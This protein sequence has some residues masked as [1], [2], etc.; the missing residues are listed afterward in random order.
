MLAVICII[1]P[2][3]KKDRICECKTSSIVVNSNNT[4]TTNTVNDVVYLNTTH[5][6]AKLSCV[7]SKSVKVNTNT[8]V[9]TDN[10]CKLK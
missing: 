9:T 8:T 6:T 5:R 10:D 2:S 7:H 3:C 1:M 4:N